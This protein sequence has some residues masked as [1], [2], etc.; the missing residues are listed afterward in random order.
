MITKKMFKFAN[1]LKTVTEMKQNPMV[2]LH[3]NQ[4]VET[5]GKIVILLTKSSISEKDKEKLVELGK[6]HY[7][8][9]LKMEH[10]K[11]I[12]IFSLTLFFKI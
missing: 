5:L 11:V 9:G 6:K 4:V 8:F 1:N 10:F 12:Y 3:G 2:R 7:H